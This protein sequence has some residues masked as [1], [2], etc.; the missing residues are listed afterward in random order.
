[1][2]EMLWC[3]HSNETLLAD[4]WHGAFYFLRFYQ[5]ELLVSSHSGLCKEQVKVMVVMMLSNFTVMDQCYHSFSSHT[6]ICNSMEYWMNEW[7]KS[8]FHSL[9]NQCVNN[10]KFDLPWLFLL[11]SWPFLL[12]HYCR[13]SCSVDQ[14]NL[15]S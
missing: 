6:T 13:V 12:C 14:S 11:I 5:R 7:I 2:D 9:E 15:E 1:M 4:F 3:Y 10:G 8:I